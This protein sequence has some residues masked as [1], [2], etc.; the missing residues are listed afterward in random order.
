MRQR[1][2]QVPTDIERLLPSA[3]EDNSGVGINYAD[4]YLKAFKTTLDDGRKVLAKRRGLKITLKVGDR[5][6]E[7]LM[8]RLEHGPEVETILR[9]ALEEAAAQAGVVVSVDEDV[10]FLEQV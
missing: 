5:Q 2:A 8:R 9:R 4:A 7:G 1:V 10:I 6:G 3:E